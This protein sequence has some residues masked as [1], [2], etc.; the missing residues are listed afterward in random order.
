MSR[1]KLVSKIAKYPFLV[2]SQLWVLHHMYT[3]LLATV[4]VHCPIV[5]YTPCMEVYCE[6][7]SVDFQ[8]IGR[9]YVWFTC[10][11]AGRVVLCC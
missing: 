9:H 1:G 7:N 2:R 8:Y 4:G 3:L 6:G 5:K 11:V 10:S